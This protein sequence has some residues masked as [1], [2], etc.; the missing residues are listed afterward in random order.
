MPFRREDTNS[1]QN[2]KN[3][4]KIQ[5]E[6]QRNRAK[7][8]QQRAADDAAIGAIQKRRD[9]RAAER[10]AAERRRADL[11]ASLTELTP[12]GMRERARRLGGDCTVTRRQPRGT[13]VTLLVPLRFPAERRTDTDE[14][15]G[16]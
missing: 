13:V 3:R 11:H 2:E 14:E 10:R 15:I 1:I 4:L 12:D 5:A 9:R 8:E 7:L 16:A 6:M